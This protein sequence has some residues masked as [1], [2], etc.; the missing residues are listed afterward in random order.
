MFILE[1]KNKVP[2]TA[3]L[4]MA[5]YTKVYIIGIHRLNYMNIATNKKTETFINLILTY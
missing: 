4:K 5:I 2:S 1:D 3:F